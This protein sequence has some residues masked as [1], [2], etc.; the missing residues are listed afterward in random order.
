VLPLAYPKLELP[1]CHEVI[2]FRAIETVLKTD[3]TLKRVTKHFNAWTGDPSDVIGPTFALCP[4]L[5]ISPAPMPSNWESEG[6]H[7]MPMAIGL[8][9]VVAGSNRDQLMNY[10]ATIRHALWPPD[11]QSERFATVRKLVQDARITRP[12]LQA[13]AYGVKA[14]ESGVRLLAAEGTLKLTLLVNTP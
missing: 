11:T 4:Y 3:P 9:C 7:S 8:L 10:W 5:Q 12:V 2:A 1:D 6:Q 14:E 13:N